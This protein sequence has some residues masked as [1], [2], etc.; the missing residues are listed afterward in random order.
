[1]ASD[2]RWGQLSPLRARVVC[3]LLKVEEMSPGGIAL[4]PDLVRQNVQGVSRVLAV[5]PECVATRCG[6]LVL[7]PSGFGVPITLKPEASGPG[8]DVLVV[9]EEDLVATFG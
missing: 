1:M 5:G 9:N 2:Y 6:D 4:P 8:L 3:L 7:V